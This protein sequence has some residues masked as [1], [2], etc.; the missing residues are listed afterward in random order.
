[1]EKKH[2]FK[3]NIGLNQNNP[4][5]VRVAEILNR[6]GRGKAEY[7][8][9]AVLAYEKQGVG[10]VSGVAVSYEELEMLVRRILKEQVSGK[11]GRGEKQFEVVETEGRRLDEQDRKSGELNSDDMGEVLKALAGFRGSV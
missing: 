8:V 4:D 10:S 2:E 9:K 3:F 5:H 11:I 7:V 1:M 6:L